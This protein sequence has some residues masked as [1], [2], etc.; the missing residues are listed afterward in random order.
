MYLCHTNMKTQYMLE[1]KSLK[2]GITK[3][4]VNTPGIY[5][6]LCRQNWILQEP[7]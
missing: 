3:S 5:S 6:Y 4:R 2:L 7:L 1:I